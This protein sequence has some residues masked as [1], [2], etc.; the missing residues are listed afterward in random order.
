MA[1]AAVDTG[2]WHLKA[3]LLGQPL[4]RLLGAVRDRVPVYGSGGFTSCT[5]EEP[6]AQLT[7]WAAGDRIGRVK[8]KVGTAWGSRPHRDLER[9]SRVRGALGG[10]LLLYVD[11]NGGDARKQ[12]VRLGQAGRMRSSGCPLSM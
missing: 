10:Q 6:V 1:I 4:C 8:M 11:A 7:G 5:D 9:V 2:L 3:R 12:A